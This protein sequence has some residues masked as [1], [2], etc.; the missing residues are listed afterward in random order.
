MKSLKY[1]AWITIILFVVACN[2]EKKTIEA[3]LNTENEIESQM[4]KKQVVYQVF[5]RLFGNTNTIRIIELN[6]K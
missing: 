1:S 5:T 4:K 6:M 2:N 3:E